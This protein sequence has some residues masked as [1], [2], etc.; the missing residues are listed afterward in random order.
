MQRRIVRLIVSRVTGSDTPVRELRHTKAQRDWALSWRRG[1]QLFVHRHDAKCAGSQHS[2]QW[3]PFDSASDWNRRRFLSKR[4][5]Q[6]L[7]LL[8]NHYRVHICGHLGQ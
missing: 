6:R 1:L 3:R 5:G 8:H 7:D 4:H 2:L